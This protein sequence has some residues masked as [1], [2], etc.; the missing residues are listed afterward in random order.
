M[1]RLIFALAAGA[2]FLGQTDLSAVPP[3]EDGKPNKPPH[4]PDGPMRDK[5]RDKFLENMSPD[6][7]KRFEAAREKALQ[8]PRIQELRKNADRANGEFF[9]A[10][11]EKMMEIDPELAEIVKQKAG[12][13][14]GGKMDKEGRERGPGPA[15]GMGNLSEA[16]RQKLMTARETAKKDPAV[17]AAE[18]KKQAAQTPAERQ[19]AGDEYRKAMNEAILK[20]DPSLGP[21]IEKMAPKPP[22]HPPGPGGDG[23]PMM[24]E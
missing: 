6:L 22:P 18:Q 1:K 15:P 16:D 5:M 17:Q 23:E 19:A 13:G 2:M 11:R 7:R 12:G 24:A 20:A 9:K 8:D 21:V 3:E 4:G 14:K 10:M